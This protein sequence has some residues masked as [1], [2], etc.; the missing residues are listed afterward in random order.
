MFGG[1][2]RDVALGADFAAYGVKGSA[3]AFGPEKSDDTYGWGDE[4][5]GFIGGWVDGCGLGEAVV[6]VLE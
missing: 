1:F 3:F 6:E 2:D 5:K 4:V